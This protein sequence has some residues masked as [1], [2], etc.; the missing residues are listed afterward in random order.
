[1]TRIHGWEKALQQFLTEYRNRP[2]EWAVNDC[3]TFAGEWIKRATGETVFA[4]DYTDA[5][6]AGRRMGG[7][8]EFAAAVTQVLG[9]PVTN[10]AAASRG[11]VALVGIEGRSCLGVVEGM[12]VAAPGEQG[13][14]LIPRT[15]ILSLWSI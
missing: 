6:G 15:A 10:I 11:D 12:Y 8:A 3:A 9:E 1:M 4:P 7:Q 14:T 2:F 5:L 13:M